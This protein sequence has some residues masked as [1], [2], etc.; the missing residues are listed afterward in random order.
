M[1]IRKAELLRQPDTARMG[2]AEGLLREALKSA[3][4]QNAGTLVLKSASRLALHLA[5]TGR[6]SEA[7]DI[8]M[9]FAPL[10]NALK[11]SQDAQLAQ[12]LL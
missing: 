2:E 1:L 3:R 9:E 5:E 8:V 7:A 4:E 10:I 12:S 11:T 6:R